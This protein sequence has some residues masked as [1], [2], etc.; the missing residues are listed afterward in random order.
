[1]EHTKE[2]LSSLTLKFSENLMQQAIKK[3]EEFGKSLLKESNFSAFVFLVLFIFVYCGLL[4]LVL[5]FTTNAYDELFVFEGIFVFLYFTPPWIV[6]FVLP[7]ISSL[8]R[9]VSKKERKEAEAAGVTPISTL[10]YLQVSLYVH[11]NK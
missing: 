11:I 7:L 8:Q 5:Y 6:Y 3:Q 4:P 10:D 9:S 2:H 1:M